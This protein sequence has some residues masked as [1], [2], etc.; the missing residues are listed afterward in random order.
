MTHFECYR[1][2]VNQHASS[3]WLQIHL[4]VSFCSLTLL[5]LAYN[6]LTVEGAL[7]LVNVVK[8]TPQTALEEINIC[9][10]NCG[11]VS[12]DIL[13]PFNKAQLLDI[14][15]VI[16][17]HLVLLKKQNVLVNETFV[18]LLEVTC[19]EHPC[20]EVQYGGV[21]GFIAKKPPKRVDPMKVIQVGLVPL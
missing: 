14:L 3:L 9:V 8:N 2:V 10:S 12:G 20:L 5:Q 17:F 21:G 1:W 18:H 7:A 6:S 13:A 4:K 19:Q 11:T 16:L 15:Y